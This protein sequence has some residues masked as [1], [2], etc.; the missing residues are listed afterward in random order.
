MLRYDARYDVF[1][2]L[3]ER[4]QSSSGAVYILMDPMSR[5]DLSMLDGFKRK[6]YTVDL[7]R[8]GMRSELCPYVLEVESMNDDV[9]KESVN[10][11]WEHREDWQKPQPVCGWISSPL[12]ASALA[13]AILVQA[14][15]TAAD[16]TRHLNRFYDPRVARHATFALTVSEDFPGAL[17][18]YQLG[19]DGELQELP[20]NV[21][22][23]CQPTYM[24]HSQDPHAEWC[25][26]INAAI[27]QLQRMGV[28][29]VHHEEE[30]QR[31]V[32]T[33]M[34]LGLP[35]SE[36]ADATTFLLHKVLVHPQIE[37]HPVIAG[38]LREVAGR[39]ASYADLCS[40]ADSEWWC[41]VEKG[42]W[43]NDMKGI[44]LEVGHG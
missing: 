40:Q 43:I 7:E 21:R 6:R 18:W 26:P 30:L 17:A 14:V 22:V 36:V 16:R 19:W 1:V 28:A 24:L 20:C 35:A 25:I 11:A 29:S 27:S 15:T 37:K 33:G 10:V 5:C 31:A 44:K 9:L 41:G 4:I 39:T 23:A 42:A 12:S 2:G 8:F 38:W 34:S 32:R 3:K 13:S